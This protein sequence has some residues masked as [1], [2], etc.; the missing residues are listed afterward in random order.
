ML[1]YILLF[2]ISFPFVFLFWPRYSFEID[3]EGNKMWYKNSKLHRDDGPAIEN[4]DGSFEYWI[5]GIKLNLPNVKLNKEQI[6]FY[7]T[8]M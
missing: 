3:V 6:D 8:F 7:I 4:I 1:I 5:N 2:L